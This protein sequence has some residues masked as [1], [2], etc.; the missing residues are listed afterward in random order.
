VEESEYRYF[1][2]FPG[3]CCD[4]A[5]LRLDVVWFLERKLQA[6]EVVGVCESAACLAES[7]ECLG[8]F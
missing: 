5:L 4:L 8:V 1:F 6:F 7:F 3:L 2:D